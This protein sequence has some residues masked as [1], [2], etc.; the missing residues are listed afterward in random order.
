MEEESKGNRDCGRP[1]LLVCLVVLGV[2]I[3]RKPLSKGKGIKVFEDEVDVV[4]RS[5]QDQVSDHTSSD[6]K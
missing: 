5:S 2:A 6:V 4:T 3:R 1:E